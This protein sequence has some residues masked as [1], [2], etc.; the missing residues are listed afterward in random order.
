MLYIRFSIRLM[1]NTVQAFVDVA[2]Q[3][4]SPFEFSHWQVWSFKFLLLGL[5]SNIELF[6]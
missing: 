5:D 4:L 1:W 2:K 6:S 3:T